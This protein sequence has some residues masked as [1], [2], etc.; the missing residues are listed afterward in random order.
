MAGLLGLTARAFK[1]HEW[2]DITAAGARIPGTI[3]DNICEEKAIIIYIMQQNF[4]VKPVNNSSRGT[5][6]HVSID[7]AVFFV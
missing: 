1:Q 7:K 5:I 4:T 6:V 2:A 3:Y